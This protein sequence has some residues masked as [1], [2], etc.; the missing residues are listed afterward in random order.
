MGADRAFQQTSSLSPPDRRLVLGAGLAAFGEEC[1]FGRGVEAVVN[2]SVGRRGGRVPVAH[3]ALLARLSGCKSKKSTPPGVVVAI[4]PRPRAIG[5][6][7]FRIQIAGVPI[8]R[9]LKALE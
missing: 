2:D 9:S 3:P 4:A 1:L 6:N 8:R 7:P 5:C